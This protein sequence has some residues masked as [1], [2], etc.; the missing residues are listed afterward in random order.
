MNPSGIHRIATNVNINAHHVDHRDPASAL[1][2]EC[3]SRYLAFGDYLQPPAGSLDNANS[4]EK[5]LEAWSQLEA[6]LDDD[7]KDSS[8]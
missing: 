6:M 2:R 8:F 7:Q 1:P 5:M 4:E 3:H